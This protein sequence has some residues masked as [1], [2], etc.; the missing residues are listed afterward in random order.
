MER[1][2]ATPSGQRPSTT[3]VAPMAPNRLFTGSGL[4]GGHAYNHDFGLRTCR[5]CGA[6]RH[7]KARSLTLL[8]GDL[9]REVTVW[10]DPVF[11]LRWESDGFGGVAL[12]AQSPSGCAL[13]ARSCRLRD[14][15]YTA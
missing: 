6:M 4:A 2:H 14:R 9:V 11:S 3:G 10:R 1:R 15:L 8:P 7:C 12:L 5:L 13:L